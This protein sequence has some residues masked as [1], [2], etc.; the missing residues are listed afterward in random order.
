MYRVALCEDEPQLLEDLHRQSREILGQLEPDHEIVLFSSAEALDAAL[1][2]G[3]RFDLLC[4]DILMGGS[5]KTGMELALEL[6]RRDEQTSILF[7]TS[8]TDFLLEG[9]GARPIQYLLKPLK[10]EALETA[11]QTDL[12]LN[13]RPRTVTLRSR[14]KTTV[15][16]LKDIWYVE[17]RNHGCIFHLK[18]G[19]QAFQFTLAQAE[20][21]LPKEQFGR[22]H[23]SFV[24]NLAHIREV[25]SREVIL[26]G[27]VR[28]TIG[29]RYA[30]EFQGTFVRY[31]NSR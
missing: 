3:S 30:K 4:L 12:R 11:L 19:E 1:T 7:I 17:S 26:D 24:A 28:L 14:G 6:R 2:A 23:N 5:G 13:H 9:Y 18:R 27:G 15:L 8:S 31:L 29:R 21:L 22:C 25:T 16:A 10:R 20:E